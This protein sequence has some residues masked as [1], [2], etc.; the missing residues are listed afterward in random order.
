M[1]LRAAS[2]VVA[3]VRTPLVFLTARGSTEDTLHGF[4]VGGDDYVVKPF[5]LSELV[6]RGI[7]TFCAGGK[8]EA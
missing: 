2:V 8:V 1:S 5:M 6:A 4:R 7:T 3:S